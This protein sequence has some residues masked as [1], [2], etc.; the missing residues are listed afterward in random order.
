MAFQ[1]DKVVPWGRNF[2]EYKSMF[3]LTEEDLGGR[4]V[5]FGDGP[6][7][8]NYELSMKGGRIISLDPIYQFDTEQI[9]RQISS[10][11][12]IVIQQTRENKENYIWT[13]IRSLEELEC[14][15]MEAMNRFLDDYEKGRYEG[16]YISHELPARTEYS[17]DYFDIGLSSHFL[18]LYKELGTEFHKQAISEM[19]R[20]CKEVRIFPI[21]DLDGNISD[22]TKEVIEYFNKSYTVDTIIVD[23]QF[24]KKGNQMLRIRKRGV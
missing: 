12:D 24:Q 21:V 14:I 10:T 2:N 17:D 19:I 3:S 15:R 1:L 13:S 5:G 18:F 22:V 9:R 6:A 4:I 20:I 7:S 11:K 16:R 23:Y 8:F